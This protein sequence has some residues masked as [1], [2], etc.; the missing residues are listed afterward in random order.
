[1]WEALRKKF[2]ADD[3]DDMTGLIN[4]FVMSRMDPK[5]DPEEWV[6]SRME[7]TSQEM[8]ASMTRTEAGRQ[9]FRNACHAKHKINSQRVRKQE[10]EEQCQ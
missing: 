9:Y 7:I 4:D 6:T 10:N 1:M 2:E 5:E 8:G 3:D